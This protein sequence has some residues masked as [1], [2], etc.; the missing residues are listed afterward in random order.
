MKVCSN[1]LLSNVFSGRHTFFLNKV[2]CRNLK[3]TVKLFI[4][5]RSYF[6]RQGFPGTNGYFMLI[7]MD[8]VLIILCLVNVYLMLYYITVPQTIDLENDII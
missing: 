2:I 4:G 8:S 3:Q 5:V 6:P 1:K 7:Q